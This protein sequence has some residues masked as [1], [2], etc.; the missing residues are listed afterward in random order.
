LAWL[1][2]FVGV[3]RQAAAKKDGRSIEVAPAL[4]ISE[5]A[6]AYIVHPPPRY[7]LQATVFAT[8]GAVVLIPESWKP[9]GR[10]G[11]FA[12]SAGLLVLG[13]VGSL[14]SSYR[15]TFRASEG[16]LE[17]EVLALAESLVDEGVIGVYSMDALLQWQLMFYGK[18]RV[19]ARFASPVDRRPEYPE[20]VD[21]ALMGGRS[22]A[23]IGTMAQAPPILGTP[24]GDRLVP[25]GE[26]FFYIRDVDRPLLE[27]LGFRFKD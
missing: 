25:V 14:V 2:V 24:L 13:I 20:A 7:F 22:V 9:L 10:Q 26:T 19:P 15:P 27:S 4:V 16:P 17:A 8:L 6:L 12:A 21:G 11:R 1:F 3:S 23:L 5:G 18:E